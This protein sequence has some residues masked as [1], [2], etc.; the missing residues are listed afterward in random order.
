MLAVWIGADQ[1]IVD[2]LSGAGIPELSDRRRCGA[3]LHASGAASRGGG[4]AGAGSA[5]HAQRVCARCRMPPG[6]SSP[7]RWP[8]AAIG[9]IRSRSS[10]CS[11]PM[12]SRWSRHSPPPMPSRRS[13]MRPMFAQGA[14]VVLKIM[15]RDIVHKS[16]V[17]GVVLNLTS[18]DAVRAAT[19]DILARAK[20]LRPEARISGVMV[21]ADG[22]AAEGARAHPRPR[23]RSDLRHRHRVRPRRHG[24]RDH[25]RQGAGASAARSATGAQPDRA[26]PCL[27]AVARLSRCAGGEARRGRDGS[28]QAGADGRGHSRDPRTRHQS[29]AGG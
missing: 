16:D 29:A 4:S 6:R 9:S 24:G 18:A 15:S 14:T 20:V 23:R 25:Q 22:G 12:T 28:G 2:L 17:G 19:A 1:T 11:R 10:G 7:P 27:A 26:H 5:G 13:L 8:M 21:Q 3:R